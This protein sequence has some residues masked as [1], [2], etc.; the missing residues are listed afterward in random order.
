MI[1]SM[2]QPQYLPWIPYF[3]K[4]LIADTFVFLDNVQ[5][6]KNGIIN[7]NHLKN[8]YGKFWL[9]V[10]VL[11]PTNKKIFEVQIDNNNNW[12]KKHLSSI[13]QNYFKSPNYVF[14]KKN[15]YPILNKVNDNIADLNIALITV[16]LEK[17]FNKKINIIR[18]KDINTQ[19]NGTDLI[20][21][22]CKN[23]KATQYVS[24]PGGKKYLEIEKFNYN[25]IKL[26]FIENYLPHQYQQQYN[27]IGF[28]PDL[29]ALDFILNVH[30][31]YNTYININR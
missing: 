30:S 27:R 3:N 24:G 31:D 13:Q 16:I 14:F 8:S 1:L 17:Y 19:K 15:L 20:I 21:E 28:M 11:H 5:Y 2:H 4:I 6:Q 26:K 10:P 7:R 12:V 23:L 25:G 22:I 29:S 9:T 18:Q